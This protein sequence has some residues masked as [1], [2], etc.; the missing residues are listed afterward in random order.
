MQ[1]SDGLGGLSMLGVC[2]MVHCQPEGG[3]HVDLARR[4]SLQ[5]EL[6][7]LCHLACLVVSIQD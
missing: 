7:G 1:P 2:M 3:Q 5:G 6:A 4:R